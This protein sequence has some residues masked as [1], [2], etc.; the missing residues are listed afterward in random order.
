MALMDRRHWQSRRHGLPAP[1]IS[2]L[3]GAVGG[4][5]RKRSERSGL[6]SEVARRMLD[7]LRHSARLLNQVGTG[8]ERAIDPPA[9]PATR[10]RRRPAATGKAAARRPRARKSKPDSPV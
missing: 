4:W 7:V 10:P 6:E 8:L 5:L 3:A 2:E 9:S 1:E